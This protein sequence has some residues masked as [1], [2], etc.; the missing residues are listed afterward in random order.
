MGNAAAAEADEKAAKELPRD[1]PS[2]NAFAFFIFL[3]H[4]FDWAYIAAAFAV[5]F[6][7]RKPLRSAGIAAGVGLFQGMVGSRFELIDLLFSLEGWAIWIN[8]RQ[9][10]IPLM[11]SVAAS[12]LLWA[13]AYGLTKAVRY[14]TQPPASTEA[15]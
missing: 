9:G 7:V 2:A 10:M 4:L 3:G 15:A 11:I 1:W 12:L 6:L 5:A 14:G 13:V 8:P